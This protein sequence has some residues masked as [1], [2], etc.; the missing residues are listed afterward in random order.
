[1]NSYYNG[2]NSIMESMRA[3]PNVQY[4]EYVQQIGGTSGL[5]EMNFGN[6]TTWPLQVDGRATAQECLDTDICKINMQKLVDWSQNE[7]PF[8]DPT[9]TKRFQAFIADNFFN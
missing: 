6:E 2:M 8:N 4:R 7:Q 1:M 5:A 3:Y 9:Y